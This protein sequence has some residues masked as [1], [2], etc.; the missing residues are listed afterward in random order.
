M[1]LYK[2]DPKIDAFIIPRTRFVK[3][4]SSQWKVGRVVTDTTYHI[5]V[6]PL[7]MP[8]SKMYLVKET[9]MIH[10]AI[11]GLTQQVV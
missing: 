2:F 11:A 6:R 7:K 3:Y 1:Y 4:A 5:T 9:A 8:G 10:S